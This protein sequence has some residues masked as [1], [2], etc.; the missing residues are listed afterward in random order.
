TSPSGKW[1]VFVGELDG[2]WQFVPIQV[3]RPQTDL[4]LIRDDGSGLRRLTSDGKSYDPS[5]SPSGER[6]AFVRE[7]N[8]AV[9]SVRTGETRILQGL[10]GSRPYTWECD[11][12]EFERPT[13]APNGRAIAAVAGNGCG[14]DGGTV[15]DAA[16]GRAIIQ[17]S[18]ATN[19]Q[20][21]KGSELDL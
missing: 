10:R 8:V 9:L 19:Y 13:W 18:S 2:G 5:W 12:F 1:R 11:Y 16:S 4:W 17:F 20:W 6:I 21:D 3:S 7:G 15:A 14:S